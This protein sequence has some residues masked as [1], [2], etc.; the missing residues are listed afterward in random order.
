MTKG[1]ERFIYSVAMLDK[2]MIH[3]LSVMEQP[4]QDFITPLKTVCN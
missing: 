3:V 1:V 4:L 2:E